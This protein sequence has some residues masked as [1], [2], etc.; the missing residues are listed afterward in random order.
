MARE[1]LRIGFVG[2]G[3]MG[4]CAHLRNYATLPDCEVAA[5]AELR[6]ELARAVAARYGVPRVYRDHAEMLRRERLDAVVAAHAF[7][8]HGALL[9]E[10]LSAGRPLFTEKPLASTVEAGERIVRAAAE[11]GTWHMVGYHKRSDPAAEYAKAEVDRLKSTGELGRLRYVRLLMPAGD[12]VAAGFT[13]LVRT[14]ERLPELAVDPPA[15]DMDG[16]TFDRYVSFVNYYIHQVNLMRFLLGEPYEPAWADP[17]GVLMTCVSASGVTGSL[18]MSPYQTTLD[19][20]ESALVAFEKG[21]VRL[22]L[23]APLASNRPGR[24]EL[25]RDP[26]GGE[27]PR[28][29]VPQL[30]WVHA[31]RSQAAS[32]LAAVRGERRPPCDSVEALEDLRTA[33]GYIRLWK[34]V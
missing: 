28:T 14:D 3:S 10:L 23:P 2:V 18:E 1:K 19:W 26:G 22:D 32:F 33:R 13:D 9:P 31:M 16:P 21:Y 29:V 12:W 8:R 30:P 34:G 25:F 6:P 5:I 11:A 17:S 24:V 27:Q 20:Q 7:T 4:Q 15:R